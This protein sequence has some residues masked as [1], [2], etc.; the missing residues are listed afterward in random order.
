MLNSSQFCTSLYFLLTTPYPYVNQSVPRIEDQFSLHR[1]YIIF[2][3]LGLR[4]LTVVDKL[5]RVVGIVTRKD[6][7]GFNVE[8]K[9]EQRKRRGYSVIGGAQ[10][11]LPSEQQQQHQQQ[12]H[13]HPHKKSVNADEVSLLAEPSGIMSST[14]PKV[15]LPNVYE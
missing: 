2:R 4:H 13:P 3:T 9:L 1:T 7:M 5:N 11:H 8:E 6:L 14:V 12:L 15:Q 10:K